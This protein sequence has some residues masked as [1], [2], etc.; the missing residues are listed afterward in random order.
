MNAVPSRSRQ[1]C[2]VA[3]GEGT[4]ASG[5]T[6]WLRFSPQAHIDLVRLEDFLWHPGDPQAH[7]MMPFILDALQIL[8]HQPGVG[9]RPER[10]PGPLPLGQATSHRARAAHPPPTRSRLRRRR[11]LT[12]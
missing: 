10:L 12:F 3:E 6:L 8:T 5:A 2:T 9:L 4:P 11:G 1:T 7:Q